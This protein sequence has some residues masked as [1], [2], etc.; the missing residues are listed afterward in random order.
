M[1]DHYNASSIRVPPEPEVSERFMF[2][3]VADLSRSDP[4]IATECITS[5]T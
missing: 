4:R 2:A 1:T 3:R 5:A